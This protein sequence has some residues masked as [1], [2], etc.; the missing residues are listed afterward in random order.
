MLKNI[1][2]AIGLRYIRAKR[3]N[4]FI[5]F[6]SGFSLLG[7]ALGV[8]ALIVVMS[9]MNGFDREMKQRLLR[10]IPHGFI[11]QEPAMQ[12]WQAMRTQLLTNTDIIA[13]APFVEGFAL[14][15]FSSEIQAVQ[16]SGIDPELQGDV[17]AVAD[18]MLIGELSSLQEGQFGIVLGAVLARQ[19]RVITGDKLTLTLPDIAITA[20]GV[21]PR[22]KRFTVV[23]IFE[24]NAPV[25]QELALIHIADAQKL[26]RTQAPMGL[27]LKF[28][29]IYQAGAITSRLRQTLGSDYQLHDW[30]QTQGSL[31]QAVKMEKIVIGVLLS[32]IIAVAAFNIVSSLVLMVADKRSDIAVL[33][34]LGL[35]ARQIMGIFMVQGCGVGVIGTA[36]GALAGVLLAYYISPVVAFFE[37]LTGQQVFDADVYFIS[38]LPSQLQ[39]A[40]VATIC[41]VALLLS[42][43]ATLYPAWRAGRIQPA[44]ALRYE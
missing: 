39:W 12:N 35:N 10:V 8:M 36:V 2:L 9:V 3:R 15:G 42:F 34:T 13:A 4:Q 24:V 32:I 6:V 43:L 27:Q 19:L 31:F 18:N 20:A 14:A 7:M 1:P 38:H 17:S 41:S 29:D 21:F 25:D 16:V 44:E 26:Y 22:V 37:T 28:T 11:T 30:S 40:D 5:S 33:R 23:G